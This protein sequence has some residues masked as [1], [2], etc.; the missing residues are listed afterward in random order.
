[1]PTL[2]ASIPESNTD[3]M[4]RVPTYLTSSPISGLGVFSSGTILKGSLIWSFEDGF[5]KRFTREEFAELKPEMRE[6]LENYSYRS[7]LDDLIYVPFDNDR[8]MNHSF[9]ANT[10]FG[11]DGNFY[12]L[13][14]MNAG[15]EITCNYKEFNA[16]W[17]EYSY[18]FL[19]EPAKDAA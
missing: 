4:I 19:G 15:E 12:A 16:N 1:M 2:S 18:I 9:E 3:Y 13:R 11:K 6:F 7:V 8:Y 5:D 14:D 10:Y 17:D